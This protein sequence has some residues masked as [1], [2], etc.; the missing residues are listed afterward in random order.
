MKDFEFITEEEWHRH[1]APIL[2]QDAEYYR[3][4]LNKLLNEKAQK[5]VTELH[6]RPPTIVCPKITGPKYG[7]E[8]HEAFVFLRP[9]EDEKECVWCRLV[10][11]GMSIFTGDPKDIDG[12]KCPEC[13]KVFH[14]V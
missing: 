2:H 14:N 11:F 1:G 6:A 13:G 3:A 12:W 10:E 7:G 4:S 5:G 9:I 8:T